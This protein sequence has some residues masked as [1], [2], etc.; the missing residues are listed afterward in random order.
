MTT[1]DVSTAPLGL[2]RIHKHCV[3]M[4]LQV[5]F[6]YSLVLVRVCVCLRD[7][8]L[9]TM[10]L[11]VGDVR[12]GMKLQVFRSCF[13]ALLVSLCVAGQG[14]TGELKY[15]VFALIIWGLATL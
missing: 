10:C 2:F 1:V 12:V 9:D 6:T 4:G 14:S 5:I 8:L 15:C 11:F 3:L 13:Q 7:S